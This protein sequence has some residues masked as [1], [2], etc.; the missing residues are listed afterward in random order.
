[1]PKSTKSWHKTF[2]GS[3]ERQ[4]YFSCALKIELKTF[5]VSWH[6]SQR[7]QFSVGTLEYEREKNWIS[8]FG[9]FQWNGVLR[10]NGL[11]SGGGS[12]NTVENSR[13]NDI[14]NENLFVALVRKV[15]RWIRC[16]W[17]FIRCVRFVLVLNVRADNAPN[18]DE[19]L[20]MNS[21]YIE[22]SDG[23]CRRH[24]NTETHMRLEISIETN[25]RSFFFARLFLGQSSIEG[26]I[27]LRRLFSHSSNKR[28]K[29]KSKKIFFPFFLDN[30]NVTLE[31]RVWQRFIFLMWKGSFILTYS[32]I[33]W[34]FLL[35]VSRSERGLFLALENP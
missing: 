32:S 2:I 34:Q 33:E 24:S 8:C 6:F 1:M 20:S 35:F 3:T 27:T 5:F 30:K 11:C 29:D 23:N 14:S 13:Y 9:S 26:V 12:K 7:N 10:S 17:V 22:K 4:N 16:C 28:S 19:L 25:F 31:R 15:R 18:V 21:V